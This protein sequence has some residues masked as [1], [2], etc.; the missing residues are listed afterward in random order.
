MSPRKTDPS[1]QGSQKPV[2]AEEIELLRHQIRR[3]GELISES[4][5]LEELISVLQSTSAACAR[6]ARLVETQFRM[7]GGKSDLDA[8]LQEALEEIGREISNREN[9]KGEQSERKVS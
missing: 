1:R 8:I 2:L 7:S 6:L 4:D 5:D 3:V 9:P